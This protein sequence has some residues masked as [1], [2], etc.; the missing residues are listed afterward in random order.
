V[1]K[2]AADGRT[3]RKGVGRVACL[4]PKKPWKLRA[5]LLRI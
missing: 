4:T 2:V 5:K 1:V 3:W